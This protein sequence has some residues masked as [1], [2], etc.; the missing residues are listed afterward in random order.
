VFPGSFDPATVAHLA[1]A[2]T[3]L[4]QFGLDRVD[5]VI[6]EVALGK[7]A[8]ATTPATER[9]AALLRLTGQ[10]SGIG[11]RL[12]SSQLLADIADGYDAV[13]LGADK[14]AQILDASWYGGSA[15]ARD[16]AI[17]RLPLILIAPRPPFPLPDPASP[18]I[19]ILRLA[20]EHAA[21]SSSAVRK[22]RREWMA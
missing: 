12:T 16:E 7:E 13:I 22:G 18:R 20:D 14:W 2:D 3:A 4:D 8:R 6:S 5:L 1:I 17:A 15:V 19:G 21:V 10:R 9:L 11:A